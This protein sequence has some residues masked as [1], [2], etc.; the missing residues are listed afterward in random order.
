M[1]VPAL[2]HEDFLLCSGYRLN[3]LALIAFI[4]AFDHNVDAGLATRR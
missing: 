4:A 3:A 1:F 2:R